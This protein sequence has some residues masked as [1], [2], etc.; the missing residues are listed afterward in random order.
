VSKLNLNWHEIDRFLMGEA[1]SGSQIKQHLTE[2]SDVIGPRWGGS[3]EDRRAAAYIRDQMEAAGV[4]R[5][6]VE[7]FTLETWNHGN[8]SI[9]LPD[10]NNRQIAAL[11]FL[12]CKAIDLTTPLVDAGHGSPHEVAVLGDRIQ[13]SVVLATIAPEPF[14]APEPFSARIVRLAEAGAA[15]IIAIEPKT[16]GRME[17]ANSDELLNVG[18][19]KNAVAVVKT[20]SED[21]AYLRRIAG[22]SP[23]IS[24]SVDAEYF[25]AEA[26]NTV[27]E[28]TGST[29][30][31]RHLILAGH[32]D[33]VLKSPGGNDNTSGTIGVM[34]TARVM[35]A[36]VKELG[37]RPGMSIRFATWSGEEQ[38]LQGARSYV[39]RHYSDSSE[40]REEKPLLNINLDELSTGHMKGIVLAFPHLRQ[41]MQSQLD[42]MDDGLKC[43]VLSHMDAH[44][45]HFPFVEEAIDASITWRWRFWGRHENA[46]FHHE[47]GDAANKLN[48]RELKEY[49]GQ[50]A[51]LLLRL[52][53]VAPEDWPENPLT[54]SDVNKMIEH[55]AGGH[56]P[57]FH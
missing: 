22:G 6:E 48:V 28:I 5:A 25:D 40:S 16:G 13:G 36:L 54:I 24:V 15:C 34:E 18:P 1:W 46:N 57:A 4:D 42:T 21:G 29:H 7:P 53:H 19:Q 10:D 9:S 3:A 17:Y 37:V 52:S 30:P 47:V 33:T 38:H 43:H 8:V 12:R 39:A 32:H 56:H 20:S 26:H 14:T 31:E 11:P 55:D 44:S 45:D 49:A 23:R 2:L 27:A 50:L 41:F 51:R 35:A